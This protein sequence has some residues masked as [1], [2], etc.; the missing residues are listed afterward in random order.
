MTLR[1][2]SI[3]SLSRFEQ[4]PSEVPTNLNLNAPSQRSVPNLK[5]CERYPRNLIFGARIE[6]G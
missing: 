2:F 5:C 1:A 4:D 6:N 3:S